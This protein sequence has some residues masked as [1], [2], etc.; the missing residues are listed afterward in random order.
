LITTWWS[1]TS[2]VVL[3]IPLIFLSRGLLIFSGSTHG[4]PRGFLIFPGVLTKLS[5]NREMRKVGMGMPH[6][7]AVYFGYLGPK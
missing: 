7:G 1:G 3:L 6:A 5:K 4:I 2:R